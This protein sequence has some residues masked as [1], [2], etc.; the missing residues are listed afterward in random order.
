MSKKSKFNI[1]RN[2]DSDKIISFRKSEYIKQR[3]MYK[4][5]FEICAAIVI[6][7]TLVI[8]ISFSTKG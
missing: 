7:E 2:P 3:D 6:I 5:L 1:I 8:A 4:L